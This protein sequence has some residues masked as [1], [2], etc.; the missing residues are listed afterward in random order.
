MV[1]AFRLEWG[2]EGLAA[3]A[4]TSS[5][6]VIV[7][8]LRF[9][10]AVCCALESN[11]T[12]LPYR[13]GDEGAADYA[14]ANGAVV[15]GRRE[16]D[17]LSLSPTDLLSAPAGTR[18]VLPSPNGSTLA[19]EARSSGATHV[20]A[21]C[22]R[23]ASAVAATARQLAEGGSI[24][25]IAAGE[26]WNAHDGPLR[27]AVEELLGAGAVLAALDPAGAVSAP[28]C[29]PK[30]AAARAAFVSTRPLIYDAL[31]NSTS[32]RELVARGW[33]DDVATSAAHDVSIVVPAL[34]DQEF[35]R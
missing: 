30:A 34:V 35:R 28:R 32:G 16:H 13:W 26:R 25:I 11:I 27:C 6:I 29:S 19:V 33:S 21:G 5:V 9:T 18:L 7:D 8:V 4:P 10:T 23:N 12:V 15:G 31:A 17:E 2:L 24:G 3:L 14:R 1:D 20:L 22:I